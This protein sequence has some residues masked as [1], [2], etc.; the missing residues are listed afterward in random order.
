MS[1]TTIVHDKSRNWEDVLRSLAEQTARPIGEDFLKTLVRNLGLALDAHLAFVAEFTDSRSRV[2]SVAAWVRD[3]FIDN[4]EYELAGTP[5]EEVLDGSFCFHPR[6]LQMRFPNLSKVKSTLKIK[7]HAESFIGV[8]LVSESGEVM[9]HLAVEDEKPMPDG[10]EAVSI[11]RIFAARAAAELERKRSDRA[12]RESENRL[13]RILASAMDAIV[14]VDEHG[15]IQLFNAAAEKMF[16]AA[17]DQA[18]G[19]DLARLTTDPF[20]QFL[21]QQFQTMSS[22]DDSSLSVWIPRGMKALRASQEPFEVE[23][24]LSKVEANWRSYYTIILRDVEER[25]RAEARL[26]SLNQEINY[27]R[28]EI[29]TQHNFAEIIGRSQGLQ[30]ILRN[31]AVVA[32]TDSSVLIHGE[33]GTGKELIARAIHNNSPRKERPLIKVNCAGLPAG[34]VE[35]ELLGHE[36]GAFTGAIARRVGRFELAHGGT[37]FL[38]EIGEIPLEAQAKLLR[39]IQER[40]FERVGGAQT[41]KVDVR[42][43]AATNRDLAKEVRT[44]KFREDLFYRLNV[45]PINLPPLRERKE[46]I[47]LLA[48]YFANKYMRKMKKNIEGLSPLTVHRLREYA[49]PGNIRELENVIERAV[50]LCTSNMLE[51]GGE[52]L[53]ASATPSTAT[54]STFAGSLE[55][56]ERAHI[57]ATLARTKGVVNGNDGAA[58]ILKINPST[59]RSRM[60][61]L[62]ITRKDYESLIAN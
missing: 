50:I 62:G 42:I 5:C 58:G 9:G 24:S 3:E 26:Q 46:D 30:S 33:S 51:I 14:T 16:G 2:T 40:E 22:Q 23:G 44:G 6:D 56:V 55:D 53:G 7:F 49:W 13:A 43:I 17:A 61:K 4:F 36:K 10:S 12:L 60:R 54:S 18:I 21:K 37:I 34:L 48:H 47:P 8:P 39:A 59:L 31:V 28:E 25:R 20:S 57:V 19:T 32:P 38:D 11:F 45:F 27:L 15:Q 29:E 1:A 35:S 52:L 41:I